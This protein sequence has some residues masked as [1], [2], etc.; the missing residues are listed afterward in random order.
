MKRAY[1]FGPIAAE[2]EWGIYLN[3]ERARVI[4]AELWKMGYAVFC[5]H[6]NTA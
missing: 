2:T 3:I 5:P 4:A 6:A 1:I